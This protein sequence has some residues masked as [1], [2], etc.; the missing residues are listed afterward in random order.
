[1]PEDTI[2][3]SIVN[4]SA[5]GT[6]EWKLHR[7][8]RLALFCEFVGHGAFGII[9]KAAWLPYFGT[10]GIPPA[11]GWQLMPLIGSID[12][13]L[14]L[15]TLLRPTR[16]VLLY[17][18]FWGLATATVRPLAGEPIWEWVERVP[19][20]AVPLAFFG[21]RSRGRAELT[22]P[23]RLHLTLGRT[24]LDWLL[25]LAVAGALV[26]HGTYGAI[27]AK[28]SWFDYFAVLGLS[29]AV[30]EATGLLRSVGG[31][32]IALGLLVLAFPAPALLL[33]LGAWKIGPELLR[34]VAGEPVW[35]FVERASNI[36]APLALLYVRG[37]PASLV[38]SFGGR[39]RS[40]VRA[41]AAATSPLPISAATASGPQPSRH[42]STVPR[43]VL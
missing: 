22:W 43:P 25:R 19:N 23:R 6:L 3:T 17:M 39:A 35:E 26:G 37:W 13:T 2:S 31:A 27:L 16:A 40:S 38:R 30:V 24:R 4:T 7:L 11:L 8:F 14:G 33:F 9:T 28:P 36:L 42:A 21:L 5:R 41:Q 20:W 10:V 34:P 29:P 1:M 12:I 15:L 18:A 32:E